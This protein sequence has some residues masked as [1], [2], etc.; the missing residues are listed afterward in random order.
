M[1]DVVLRSENLHKRCGEL[2]V[3]KGVSVEVDRAR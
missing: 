1:A 2:E 3:L